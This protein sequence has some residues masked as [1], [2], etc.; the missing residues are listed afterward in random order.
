[1]PLAPGQAAEV[2][3]VVTRELTAN[4]LGNPGVTVLATE[5][6]RRTPPGMTVRARAV[7][8]ET[9]GRRQGPRPRPD[10]LRARRWRSGWSP[11]GRP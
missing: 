5:A 6:P 3:R 1:M 11:D 2:E 9:D 8:R 7:L 10:E 4:V